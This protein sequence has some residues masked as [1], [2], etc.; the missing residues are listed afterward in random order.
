MN[1]RNVSLGSIS[2]FSV[3]HRHQR[4]SSNF[5]PLSKFLRNS[6]PWVNLRR[7]KE[8]IPCLYLRQTPLRLQILMSPTLPRLRLLLAFHQAS[9]AQMIFANFLLL[10]LKKRRPLGLSMTFLLLKHLPQPLLHVIRMSSTF[11]LE[12]WSPRHR[13]PHLHAGTHE[14]G[15][16]SWQGRPLHLRAPL[17]IPRMISHINRSILRNFLR[18]DLCISL[19]LHYEAWSLYNTPTIRFIWTIFSAS[20]Y[21]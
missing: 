11:H 15:V 7:F 19:F 5:L 21:P 20:L 3:F 14:Q 13:L 18:R 12:A 9:G 1:T 10:F 16:V 2:T 8:R 4:A 6:P 17:R